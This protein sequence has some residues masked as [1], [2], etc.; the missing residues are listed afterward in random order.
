MGDVALAVPVVQAVC[1]QNPDIHLHF[2][3][4]KAFQP[5]FHDI[6]NLSFITPDLYG[7]HKGMKGLFRLYREIA[8]KIDLEGF[9]DLHDVLRSK[10]L[11]FFFGLG[12]TKVNVIDKGRKGKK[13]LTRKEN[14][15]FHPLQHSSERYADVFRKAGLKA[16]LSQFRPF[17]IHPTQAVLDFIGDK[18]GQKIGIAPFAQHKGKA[19]PLG[20]M[21][22]VIR[23]LIAA[24]KQVFILGGGKSEAEQAQVIENEFPQVKSAIGQ[25]SSLTEEL[26]FMQQLD[27]M[28]TMDSS[29][30]HFA[31]LVGKKVY[32]IWGAT[33]PYAGFT[34]FGQNDPETF[35]QISHEELNCRPCS[36]FGNK[37]CHRGD[38]ACLNQLKPNQVVDKILAS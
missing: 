36:V 17:D 33:H 24:G 21:M 10:V 23:E 38:W 32:S 12:G 26:S 5:L 16:D 3:T 6:P 4:R 15:A 25:F 34:P 28:L 27:V 2:I 7:N 1:T 37:P 31:R 18:E 19:Y 30:M 8:S 35:I 22:E 11:R 14:K 20:H 29:N 13:A 9:L